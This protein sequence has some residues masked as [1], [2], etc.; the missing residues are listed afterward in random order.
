M[1]RLKTTVGLAALLS[2]LL[3]AGAAAAQDAEPQTE[4]GLQFEFAEKLFQIKVYK[5]AAAEYRRFLKDYPK[6]LYREEARYKLALCHA[7][8]GGAGDG[9]KALAELATLRKEFPNGKRFQD[10]LFRA[11]H[12]RY[13]LGDIK[14][15]ISDL[16]ELAKLKVRPDLAVSMHH[17][18]GRAHSDLGQFPQALKHLAIVAKAPKNAELRPYALIV[19]ADLYLKTKDLDQ[20]AATLVTLL[21]DYPKLDTADEMRVKL[22]DARL[23]L[24]QPDRALAAYEDVGDDSAY[25]DLA[26]VGKARALLRLKKYDAAVGV[27]G[28]V[29]ARFKETP[30]T[31]GRML[32]GQCLYITGLA[33]FNKEQYEPAAAAFVRLLEKVRQGPMAEDGA[34][35]LCW[36]YYR[37][38]P[39]AARK[40]VA[41]CVTFRRSF[42]A[43]KW[44]GQIVFL[45]AEGHIN[46]NDHA[47]AIIL[48]KQIGA[49]D[50]NYADALYRIAYCY[51][52]QNNVTAAAH[53]Y[54]LFVAKFGKHRKTA[55]A[56]AGA[57]GLYQAA[58]RFEDAA[59]RYAGYL[60]AAPKGPEAEEALYQRGICFAKMSQFDSMAS[61]FGAYAQ[62]FPKGKR[63]SEVSWWLGRHY[64]IRADALTEKGDD[65]AAAKDY[66]AAIG[67]FKASAALGGAGRDRAL[68]T[69]AECS[70]SLGQNQGRRAAAALAKAKDAANGQKQ[71]LEKE[72]ADLG[73]LAADSFLGAARGFLDVMTRQPDLLTDEPVYLWAGTFFRDR[74]NTPSAIQVFKVYLAKFKKSQQADAALYQLARLHGE[75]KP[76]DHKTAIEYCDQL[77]KHHGKSALV[78]Q[79]KSAKA[80]ALYLQREYVPAE[81]L[82]REVSQQGSAALKVDATLKLGHIAFARKEYAAAARYFAEIGLLYD[83]AEFASEALYFAGKANFLLKDAPE[84]VKFWQQL[85]SRYSKSASAG[86]A[87]DE[88][89][90][91]GYVVGPKGVIRKN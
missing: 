14:G 23:A 55:A 43:S 40:L 74:G 28:D 78:L 80:E 26:A 35:K 18:L 79:T 31:K 56:L 65:P 67:A 41:S 42:P 30:E 5:T 25:R 61:V 59:N 10:A 33:H 64:R 71:A 8:L 24:K 89:G 39:Q 51:H 6:S 87:R 85:L 47:N 7:K 70:Y 4:A 3:L 27:C 75:L 1:W 46:L 58:G 68:L 38:G 90:K 29:L 82:Y 57:A 60:A 53:A 76:P 84:G 34:Y 36:S 45:T 49:K 66:A 32:P 37:Q 52:R 21:R 77:L 44:A 12:V 62:Q 16:G 17:F 54:D 63:A 83:D 13:V 20:N 22:G 15:A 9:K 86:K 88:L 11:G 73:K 48:L 91:L 50:A 19:L 72:A 69:L 81:K 2:A